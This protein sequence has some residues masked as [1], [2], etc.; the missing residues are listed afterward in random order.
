MRIQFNT[1]R[2]HTEVGQRVVAQT[3]KG[4]FENCSGGSVSRHRQRLLR[5]DSS[6]V[7]QMILDHL[8]FLC[9]LDQPSIRMG[10]RWDYIQ[11]YVAER[12]K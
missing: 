5:R 2:S 12:V 10:E 8:C 1:G 3:A 7:V 6:R 9:C 11:N 4:Y